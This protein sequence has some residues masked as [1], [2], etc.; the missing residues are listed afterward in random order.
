M[1]LFKQTYQRRFFALRQG[2]KPSA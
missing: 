1:D 2:T